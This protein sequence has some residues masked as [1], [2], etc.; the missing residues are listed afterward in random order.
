MPLR[1]CQ[2]NLQ[3]GFPKSP[4]SQTEISLV[5]C[6]YDIR[7]HLAEP[8]VFLAAEIDSEVIQVVK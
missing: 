7:D 3:D 8:H 1:Y 6:I 4:N 5:I 2:N